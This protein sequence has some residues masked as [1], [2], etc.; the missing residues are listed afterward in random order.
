MEDGSQ[1]GPASTLGPK[2][3][4]AGPPI[5]LPQ[6]ALILDRDP[7]HTLEFLKTTFTSLLA[8]DLSGPW[9]QWPGVG[10]LPAPR[11]DHCR[12][13]WVSAPCPLTAANG[14]DVLVPRKLGICRQSDRCGKGLPTCDFQL[15]LR[16]TRAH[17]E[18]DSSSIFKGHLGSRERHAW[19]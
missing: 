4:A 13:S 12:K 5:S 9:L 3:M 16:A 8:S 15:G 17:V 2:S 6:V 14:W 10:K 7:T 1:E 19:P 18:T 11:Q